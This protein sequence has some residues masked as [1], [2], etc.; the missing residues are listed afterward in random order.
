MLTLLGLMKFLAAG[1]T[2]ARYIHDRE[3][4][5][6]GSAGIDRL[7]QKILD[8]KKTREFRRLELE[9]NVLENPTAIHELATLSIR[10]SIDP[11]VLNAYEHLLNQCMKAHAEGVRNCRGENEL[12]AHGRKA[13]KCVCGVLSELREFNNNILP[14][15][16]TKQAWKSYG[17]VQV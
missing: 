5:Y 9:S 8:N 4:K 2:I 10:L 16:N 13:K 7:I 14:G 15:P 6:A 12:L 11:E 3:E 17:C 1:A